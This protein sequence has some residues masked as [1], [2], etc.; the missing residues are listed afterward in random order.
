MQIT[1]LLVY[2]TYILDDSYLSSVLIICVIIQHRDK[3]FILFDQTV[4]HF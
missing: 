4:K 3:V 1:L 2:C